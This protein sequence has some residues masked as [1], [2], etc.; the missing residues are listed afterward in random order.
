[1]SHCLAGYGVEHVVLERG[2]V[3]QAWR[4]Q[5]WDSLRLLTPNW[6]SRLPGY[7]YAGPDP[8]GYMTAAQVADH[9]D[10]YRRASGAPVLTG[11]GVVGVRAARSGFR[12]DTT[13]GSWRSRAVVVASGATGD[14]LL[15]HAAAALPARI[16]QVTA[17]D[18]RRPELL[19]PGGVLVVGASASGVQIADELR[20]AGRAVTL[21]AGSHT[22]VPRTYRGRD[23][24]A[25]L[26]AIGHLD[27]RYDQVEDIAK[28]R[29]APSLQL[30]GGRP[31]RD[32]GLAGLAADGVAVVGRFVG[33][34]ERLARFSGSLAAAVTDADLRLG[35]LLDRIDAHLAE[36]GPT[37][38]YGPPDRPERVR[39]PT[40]PTELDL[41]GIAVVV[42]ATGYRP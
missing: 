21:A 18:Y 35:R 9:L 41:A 33:A 27:E 37:D 29:R 12:V 36:H 30:V 2:A 19:A 7:P 1:M 8:H 22:R 39:L 25:W 23:I 4:T 13:A 26:D 15:P 40:P 32:L 20:R 14:P 6:L 34:T 16:Q 10:G 38:A 28:A 5:R 31:R 42:W 24:H 11:T 3:A 17:L